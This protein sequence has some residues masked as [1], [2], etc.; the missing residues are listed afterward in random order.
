VTR[1]P[2]FRLSTFAFRLQ[3]AA[4]S[5]LLVC[6]A[7]GAQ[8]YPA[9]AVRMVSP[10][11]PGGSVD[12]VA[13]LVAARLSENLG[14][15]VV[16]EN[17]SGASGNIGTELVARAAPD[18]YTLLIN[19]TPFVT[20]VFL[21]SKLPYD[22]LNDFAPVMLI[23]W[24]QTLLAVHP[25][26]PVRSVRELLAMAKSRPGELNYASAGPATNPHIAG[27]LF[28]LL[29]KVNIVAVHFKGGGPG[30]IATVSGEV[31]IAFTNF[32]ETSALVK[33]GRLRALGVSGA[34]RVPAMPE[35]PTIAEAG[36]PGYEFTAWHG[37]WAPKGTPKAVV[38]LLNERLKRTMAAPDQVKRFDER[39]L[40]II[41]STPE[42]FS[43]HLQNEYKKWGRVI[44]ER[45]MKAE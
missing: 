23:S 12:L 19:T 25:S 21:Y 32:S 2:Y 20:N 10:F 37:L 16:V 14:Q 24:S 34:K 13:R 44:R 27:E 3:A 31:G 6:T 17:R 33:A 7:A 30:L 36:L 15:Q 41:A 22:P 38:A 4:L 8:E 9:R 18:G 45:G 5:L 42:E 28:N 40:E 35:V 1:G 26:L 39:G 29:G 11:P 43:T